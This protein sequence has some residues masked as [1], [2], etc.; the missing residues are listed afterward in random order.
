MNQNTQ[1]NQQDIGLV[2]VQ[3]TTENTT[4]LDEKGEESVTVEKNISVEKD[5]DEDVMKHLETDTGQ[6]NEQTQQDLKNEVPQGGTLIDDDNEGENEL[7]G[8]EN[9]LVDDENDDLF[10]QNDENETQGTTVE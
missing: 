8:D 6:I 1:D 4:N 3:T 10:I 2:R 7:A 5:D 9:D